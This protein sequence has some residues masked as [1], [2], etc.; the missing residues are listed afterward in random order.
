MFDKALLALVM[1]LATKVAKVSRDCWELFS[2]SMYLI[3]HDRYFASTD[4]HTVR[5]I[6]SIA[7]VN[8]DLHKSDDVR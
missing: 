6:M 4:S 5:S 3:E 1:I 8:D 2:D 7:I